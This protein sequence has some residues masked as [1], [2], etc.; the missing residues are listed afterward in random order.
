MHEILTQVSDS[1]MR[2]S[3]NRT[4]RKNSLTNTMYEALSKAIDEAGRDAAVKVLFL[5][6]EG[7]T[8]TAGNDLGGFVTEPP[9]DLDAPVF[10]FIG[11]LAAFTK[12]VV[13]AVEGLAIGVGTT[14]LLHCDLV[15]AGA[16]ARFAL[17]FVTL[18][19]VPEAASSLILP[20]LAGHQQAAEKLLFGDPFSAAEAFRLGFVTQVLEPNEV[21]AFALERAQALARLPSGSLCGTKRLMKAPEVTGHD[22]VRLRMA[23]EV[24]AFSERLDG[25]ALREALAAFKEKRKPDFSGMT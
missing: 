14:M 1:V 6:G 19:L 24:K 23:E 18:G 7:G 2:V 17:P 10:R 21:L 15:Y 25:P 9:R 3:F 16:N 4:E 20:R 8:F 12:P 22:A 11:K 13:A 5:C